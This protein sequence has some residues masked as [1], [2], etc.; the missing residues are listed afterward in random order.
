MDVNVGD[1]IEVPS[2]KVG[3]PQR[4]GRVME[5]VEE[6]PLEVRVAW[7]DGHETSFRPAMGMLRIV[8]HGT[9]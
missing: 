6:E 8:E 5:V 1:V 9:A 3:G 7:E 2:R 4:R